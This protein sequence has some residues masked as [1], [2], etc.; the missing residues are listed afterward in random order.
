MLNWSR[1]EKERIEGKEEKRK[2]EEKC[3]GSFLFA[4][5]VNP[6]PTLEVITARYIVG[7]ARGTINRLQRNFFSPPLTS[8]DRSKLVSAIRFHRRENFQKKRKKKGRKNSLDE[9]PIRLLVEPEARFLSSSF[10]A[11][12]YASRGF[13]RDGILTRRID[14][15]ISPVSPRD[16]RSSG[17]NKFVTEKRVP[18]QGKKKREKKTEEE[19]GKRRGA[20]DMNIQ[21]GRRTLVFNLSDGLLILRRHLLF[22]RRDIRNDGSPSIMHRWRVTTFIGRVLRPSFSNASIISILHLETPPRR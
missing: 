19:G 11:R 7:S 17:G 1:W 18:K 20:C 9:F 13:G 6:F 10:E 22:T 8:R 14:R 21:Q 12:D 16:K 4:L 5:R 2:G 3:R 15:F